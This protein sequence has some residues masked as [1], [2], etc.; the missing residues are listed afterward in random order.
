VSDRTCLHCG[1]AFVQ[2]GC[3]RPREWCYDCLAPYG[4][5]SNVEYA[6]RAARLHYFKQ[7]GVHSCCPPPRVI[8][9]RR[10][11]KRCF[12]CG[13]DVAPRHRTTCGSPECK[14]LLYRRAQ[15][16]KPEWYVAS[17]RRAR[18]RRRA[19]RTV[20]TDRY[21]P[22]AIATR[23]RWRCA[24]CGGR[25]RRGLGYN[26]PD[27]LTMD[28]IVP[29]SKGGEDVASNVQAAHRHCNTLKG[30][31]CSSRGEQLRLVG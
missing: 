7:T 9:P 2:I 15:A 31:G 24:L 29:L 19:K 16:S 17:R 18:V 8:E 25:I 1:V 30:N 21:D 28:H 4:S 12:N 11:R 5:C 20:A 14:R 6:R 10:P 22:I 26:H 13:S 3:G 27:A 23:D